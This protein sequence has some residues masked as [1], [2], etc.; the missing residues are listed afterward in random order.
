MS[1]DIFRN[2]KESLQPRLAQVVS[3]LLPGGRISGREY[4]CGSLDGGPGDSCST[5]L[6][7]GIGS[8]FATGES[9]GDIISLAAKVWNLGQ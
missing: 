8:D 1:S 6:E 4:L 5:N 3:D 9:W 7:N 2:V